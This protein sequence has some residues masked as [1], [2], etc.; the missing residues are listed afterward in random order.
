MSRILVCII[1]VSVAT[2]SGHPVAAQDDPF[3]AGPPARRQPAA[4][5]EHVANR[6]FA[7]V[8]LKAKEALAKGRKPVEVRG[9]IQTNLEKR[10]LA[11]L[12]K[13]TTLEE[14]NTPLNKVCAKISELHDIPVLVDRR[15]LEEIGLNDDNPVTI[16]VEDVTL[17]SALR[18]MLRESDLTYIVRDEVLQITTVEAAEQNLRTEMF[19]LRGKLVTRTDTLIQAI[20]ANVVP[21][22]WEA[23]GGPSTMVV[24]D[25]V[26]IVS[27]TD[28]VINQVERFLGQLAAK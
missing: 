9:L 4:S 16:K 12:E 15:A 11:S 22:T 10:V 23:L 3:K 2:I 5:P 20:Q 7:D 17:R 18:L 19:K 13:K 26:L 6:R 25:D 1:A 28:D 8:L 21:G 24:F 27:A 14:F